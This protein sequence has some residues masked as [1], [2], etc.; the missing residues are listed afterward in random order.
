[1]YTFIYIKFLSSIPVQLKFTVFASGQADNVDKALGLWTQ[2]QDE[3]V[4]V[5]D[6]FLSKL[7][8]FLHSKGLKAPFAVPTLG[9]FKT[10]HVWC[11]FLR[12]NGI[13]ESFVFCFFIHG[14][15]V[16]GKEEPEDI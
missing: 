1:M 6:Q 10:I 12:L 15:V 5:S 2:M 3:D 8:W 7:G 13:G 14:L 16:C 4:Q 9:K 11:S